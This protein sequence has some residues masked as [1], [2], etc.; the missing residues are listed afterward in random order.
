MNNL[1]RLSTWCTVL[2]VIALMISV[3][4]AAPSRGSFAGKPPTKTPTP[5]PGGPT[6]T[7][8]PPGPA[9]NVTISNTII[10]QSPT[11]IGAV[12]AC[13]RFN[14]ADLLDWGAKNFRIYADMARFEPVDD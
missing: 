12:E 14:I 10:G 4:A 1:R 9:P 13:S 3:G 5:T 6:P 8:T 2:L 11:S 7:P